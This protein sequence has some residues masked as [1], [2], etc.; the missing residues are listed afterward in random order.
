MRHFLAY[1][2]SDQV[3]FRAA[4]VQESFDYLTVPGTIAAY[5]PDATAAFVLS[6]KLEYVI[7]PRTPL[8]QDYIAVPRASHF[9]LADWHGPKV[10][11]HMGDSD[12]QESVTFDA[13]FYDPATIR[14][15]VG[16]IIDAQSRYGQRSGG[17]KKQLDRYRQLLADAQGIAAPVASNTQ[18]P[19]AFVLAPYFFTDG[20]DR[21]AETNE[22]ILAECGARSDANLISPV[23]AID[24]IATLATRVAALPPTLASSVFYWVHRFNERTV[25]ETELMEMRAA[26]RKL[27]VGRRLVNLYGGFFSICVGVVGLW[28]FNNGLGYSESREWPELSTT[29][30]APARY[31]LRPL[32]AYLSPALAQFIVDRVPDWACGCSV[33]AGRSAITLSYHDLKMHFALS[34]RWEIDLVA[35]VPSSTVAEHLLVSAATYEHRVLRVVPPGVQ[36]LDTEYLHRWARV[37]RQK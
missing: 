22:A 26:V 4:S 15:M 29:G 37:L 31:Y 28:G 27:A 3:S 10:R 16:S 25:S 34:R 24:R 1:G 35:G 19:P 23:V 8:F 14:E 33:C 17:I 2:H 7:D 6:S 5:Y 13:S 32:H 9:S 36:K 20:R 11:T 18:R 21:W 30:A 12:R